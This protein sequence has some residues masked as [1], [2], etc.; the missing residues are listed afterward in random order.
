[1]LRRLATRVI[2]W[3]VLKDTLPHTGR[4]VSASY[5]L[6]N[7]DVQKHLSRHPMDSG[8]LERR[9]VEVRCVGEFDG[10][11]TGRTFTLSG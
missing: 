5:R 7:I 6:S 11:A 2:S 8:T 9:G 3:T 4:K 1:M 10:L